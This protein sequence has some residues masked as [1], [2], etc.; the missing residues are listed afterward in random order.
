MHSTA[1]N[2]VEIEKEYALPKKGNMFF[3]LFQKKKRKEKCFWASP[4]RWESN[5]QNKAASRNRWMKPN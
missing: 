2:L 3:F 4:Q 5:R 1:R